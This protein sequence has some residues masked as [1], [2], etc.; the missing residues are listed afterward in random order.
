MR[1]GE[2]IKQYRIENNLTTAELASKCGLAKV[3]FQC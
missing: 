3:T 1:L 2:I